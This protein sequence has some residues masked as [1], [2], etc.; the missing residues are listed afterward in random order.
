MLPCSVAYIESW[1]LRFHLP[2][3]SI[4]IFRLTFPYGRQSIALQKATQDD[5]SLLDTF[6]LKTKT[7]YILIKLQPCFHT[8]DLRSDIV[9]HHITFSVLKVQQSRYISYSC[10]AGTKLSDSSEIGVFWQCLFLP[11]LPRIAIKVLPR[12]FVRIWF[13]ISE[14]TVALLFSVRSI[15]Q[16]VC[17]I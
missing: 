12:I 3:S 4:T 7:F 10:R 11:I 1:L 14:Y 15:L 5:K 8:I 2:Y 9:S 13:I 17:D 6:L 16:C